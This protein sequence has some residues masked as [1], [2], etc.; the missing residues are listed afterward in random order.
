MTAKTL[1]TTNFELFALTRLREEH[2]NSKEPVEVAVRLN[3]SDFS[4]QLVENI[5]EESNRNKDLLAKSNEA[6]KTYTQELKKM[7]KFLL[8]S[9]SPD[10]SG[11]APPDENE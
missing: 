6:L 11:I 2:L 5:L 8:D 10:N 4:L 9:G 7:R 1:Q 3:Q